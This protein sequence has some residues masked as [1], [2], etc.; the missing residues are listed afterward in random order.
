MGMLFAKSGHIF[1]KNLLSVS[2]IFGPVISLSSTIKVFE[3]LCGCLIFFFRIYSIHSK[4]SLYFSGCSLK[5]LNNIF[6]LC[7][8]MSLINF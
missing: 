1:V 5:N 6:Y 8:L 3:Y 4:F 2:T 7:F